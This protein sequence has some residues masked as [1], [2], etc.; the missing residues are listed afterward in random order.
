[1]KYLSLIVVVAAARACEPGSTTGTTQSLEAC[2][3]DFGSSASATQLRAFSSAVES[4]ATQ[5]AELDATLRTECRAIALDLG[6]SESEL[7]A[8]GSMSETEVSCR[9]AAALIERESAAVRGILGVSLVVQATPPRCEVDIDAYARCAAECDATYRA[10]SA[11]IQ[12]EG[13]ELRGQCSGSCTGQCAADVNAA[14]QGACEGT[15]SGS[16]TGECRGVCEGTCAVRDAQGNCAGSCTGT[17]RGTCSAGCTG[18]CQ[19]QCVAQAQGSCSGECRGSCSVAFTEPRCTGRA[20]PPMIDAECK[21]SCDTRINAQTRCEPGAVRVLF[22][23]ELGADRARAERLQNTLQAHFGAISS[24]TVRL[25]A[26]TEAGVSLARSGERVPS[27]VASLGAG[28]VTC[29]TTA[30]QS[31]SVSIPRVQVSLSASVAVSGAVTGTS[32]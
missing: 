5:S 26:M 30:V 3:Q 6:A 25:R 2:R 7:A 20:V 15:C 16:C 4:F 18:S 22:L 11:Q 21:A 13:G 10:G 31:L 1:M 8:S 12:C 14:C 19:G 24:A 28:A 32:M 27:A 9:R 17:C 23:G 29:S